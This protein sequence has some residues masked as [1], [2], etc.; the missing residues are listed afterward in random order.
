[1]L[2]IFYLFAEHSGFVKYILNKRELIISIDGNSKLCK[3]K[4]A[5]E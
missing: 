1:M 4:N 5:I 2:N 3:K